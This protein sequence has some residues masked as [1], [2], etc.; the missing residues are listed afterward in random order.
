MVIAL[1]NSSLKNYIG[2]MDQL[3]SLGIDNLVVAGEKATLIHLQGDNR[4]EDAQ[5][6]KDIL[7]GSIRLI[8][9][10]KPTL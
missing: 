4:R 8:D 1:E 3:N 10:K 2:L 7:P 6:I 5:K 9:T